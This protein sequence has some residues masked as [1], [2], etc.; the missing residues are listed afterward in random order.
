MFEHMTV[1]RQEAVAGLSMKENGI[2]VDCTLGGAGHSMFILSQLNERGKLFC[3]DQ[4]QMALD[5]AKEK[6]SQDPRVTLIKSNFRFIKEMLGQYGVKKVDGI[7]FD[8]GVS[9]PQLDIPERGFS[10][11]HDAPLDMRMNQ[12]HGTNA[13]DFVNYS[14]YEDM[15]RVFFMYGEEK[16]AKRIARQIE[17][18][19][20][21]SPIQTTL[22]LVEIIKAAIPAA[23]RREG[24][25][26]AK[27][28]FQAI[29]I[30]VNDELKAFEDAL[31]AS[32]GLLN[33]NGRIC[34]ITFHS[35]EDR[36][37][38]QFFKKYSTLP[39]VPR[40]LPLPLDQ[41]QPPLRLI[42]KKPIL[43]S[44]EEVRIN[45]RSRSSKLRIAERTEAK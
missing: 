9:S 21:T 33:T 13:Y 30:A 3:F 24:G 7:L 4:D 40:G 35:L 31:Q 1:L 45:K 17:A 14:S 5:H 44:Q 18:V 22:E 42:T 20:K 19:R 41:M 15:V 37:C 32:L 43:P 26:P 10:Y 38:K 27:R 28:V 11:Q 36:I 23:A 16:Y 29:R 12:E 34:V 25:H 6:F 2:Y 39:H 8:L